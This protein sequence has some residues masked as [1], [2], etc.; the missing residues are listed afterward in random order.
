MNRVP[1][2][3]QQRQ[4]RKQQRQGRQHIIIVI[5]II[6]INMAVFVIR[7]RVSGTGPLRALDVYGVV[8]MI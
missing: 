2:I 8:R 4:H 3:Q 7:N 6:T 5:I 1:N